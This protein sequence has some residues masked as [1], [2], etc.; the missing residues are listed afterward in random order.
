MGK[1]NS[2]KTR[3]KPV[4]DRLLHK[5]PTG[6]SW[7]PVLLALPAGGAASAGKKSVTPIRIHFWEGNGGEQPL[8]P[9]KSLLR[10]LVQNLAE[11]PGPKA[12]NIS[13]YSAE[14]RRL[15]IRRD[16]P[17]TREALALLETPC[18]KKVWYVLEGKSYPDVYLETDDMI[19]VVEGKRTEGKTTQ[20]TSWIARGKTGV[21]NKCSE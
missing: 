14:K 2:S 7:L 9:P 12:W 13:E 16:V 10:W 1:F 21:R 19:I 11:P 18:K 20:I 3:V 4:F 15:L 5:D 6:Q 8:F 17:T